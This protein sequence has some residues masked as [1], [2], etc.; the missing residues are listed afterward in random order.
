MNKPS[1]VVALKPQYYLMLR[2]PQICVEKVT[3][4]EVGKIH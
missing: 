1:K 2:I 3:D 4:K